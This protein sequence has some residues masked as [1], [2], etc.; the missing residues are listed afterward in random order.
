MKD[1]PNPSEPVGVI[2]LAGY[3]W[4]NNDH[5]VCLWVFS[6][7]MYWKHDTTQEFVIDKAMAYGETGTYICYTVRGYGYT[8]NENTWEPP[9]NIRGS[10][11]L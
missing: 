2:R 8:A 4:R 1:F 10:H 3:I 11:T 5:H 6:K 9:E 7:K